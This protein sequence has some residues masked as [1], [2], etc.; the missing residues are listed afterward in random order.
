MTREKVFS[1]NQQVVVDP[2]R[3]PQRP[4]MVVGIGIKYVTVEY[5]LKVGQSRNETQ[6]FHM[7]LRSPRG[8]IARGAGVDTLYTLEEWAKERALREERARL[9]RHSDFLRT[10]AQRLPIENMKRLADLLDELNPPKES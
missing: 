4:A 1:L 5:A 9:Q 7:D 6:V 2:S 8:S 3:G 10:R